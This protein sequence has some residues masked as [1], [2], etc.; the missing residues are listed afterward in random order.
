MKQQR[1]AYRQS[2]K[3]KIRVEFYVHA[4]TLTVLCVGTKIVSI[5][6]LKVNLFP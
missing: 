4:L 6:T 3:K 2:K 5:F 1:S